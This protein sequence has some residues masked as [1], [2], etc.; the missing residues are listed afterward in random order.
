[1]S[2]SKFHKYL[3]DIGLG[4]VLNLYITLGNTNIFVILMF[5]NRDS[6]I[7]PHFAN[8]FQHF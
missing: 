1:M 7:S 5:P 4:I 2:L 6:Q 3:V 8:A